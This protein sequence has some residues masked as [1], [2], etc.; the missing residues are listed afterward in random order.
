MARITTHH[1]D[2]SRPPGGLPWARL[3]RDII[4]AF[5]DVYNDLEYGLLEQLYASALAIVLEERGFHVRREVPL[6]VVF[7]GRR[8]GA[9]R[10]DAIVNE[11][12]IVEVKAGETLPIG[13]K[14]QTINY[15]RLSGLEVGL[16]L[17]FGPS[18]EFYRV[19]SSRSRNDEK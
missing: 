5:Y 7:H 14:A 12:V 15:V 3:T 9:Y 10:V 17:Y 4:G 11:A 8:I 2:E 1:S 6:D 19:V 16:L 13:S 18:P